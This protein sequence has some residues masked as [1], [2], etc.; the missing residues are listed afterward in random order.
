MTVAHFFIAASLV[1]D[2]AYGILVY[3]TNPK[4]G[5][6]RCFLLLTMILAIWMACVWNVLNATVVASAAAWLRG[7]FTA[8]QLIPTCFFLLRLAIKVPDEGWR[9]WIH[10]ARWFI[11]VNVAIAILCQTQAFMSGVTLP[12]L[13]HGGWEVAEPHYGPGFAI[14]NAYYLIAFGYVLIGYIQDIKVTRG[15]R[16]T[17]LQF[18]LLGC[19]ACILTG[20]SLAMIIPII[21]GSSRTAPMAP[22]CAIVLNAIIAYGIATK[23]IMGVALILRRIT[24][25]AL[26]T[27]LLSVVYLC[28]T[29]I[30]ASLLGLFVDEPGDWPQFIAA[31]TTAF[32]L[33]PVHGRLQRL[34]ARFFPHVRTVDV[35][36]LIRRAGR[37]LQ[38]ITTTDDLL[39]GFSEIIVSTFGIDRLVILLADDHDFREVYSNAADARPLHL[40]S[41]SPLVRAMRLNMAPLQADSLRR[42]R[43]SPLLDKAVSV[44]DK[45]TVA[46]T[47]GI[48]SKGRL[49]GMMLLGPRIS[50]RVFTAHEEDGL[51]ILANELAVALENSKLFTETRNSR[52]YND[53]LLDNLGS[54]VV[55]ANSQQIVTV[56]NRDAQRILHVTASDVIG[57]SIN[58]LPK[59]ICQ[60]LKETLATGLH[61]RNVDTQVTIPAGD[62]VYLRL[63]GSPFHGHTGENLGALVVFHDVTNLKTLQSQIRRSDRLAS[64]G[65]LSAGMAH[66]IKNPLVTIKTFTQLLP[67]RFDD[68]D[69][70]EN[71]V[72]LV[73]EEVKRIDSVVNQLLTFSRPARP[74]LHPIQMHTVIDN[75]LRLVQ[76]QLERHQIMVAK[77][78]RC[79]DDTVLGDANLLSQAF[80]NFFLNAQEAMQA[81]GI[82]K[83]GTSIVQNSQASRNRPEKRSP[84]SKTI[85]VRIE[86]SGVGIK[87][88]ELLRVFDPFFTTKSYGTGLGLAVAHGI[89][90]EQGGFIDVQSTEGKGTVFLIDFPFANSGDGS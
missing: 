48:H 82:L 55:A 10:K 75:S 39:A 40:D 7:A 79:T 1:I 72:S 78:Y 13:S 8:S 85:L 71:F 83:I 16:Q 45:L 35:P 24:A 34:V 50:G 68:V 33:A 32:A 4:R 3:A 47:V 62:R 80:V 19:G 90:D 67:E 44:M 17:E 25:T 60:T 63:G 15:L 14:F 31:L 22:A 42:R 84:G 37:T 51:R 36:T 49:T 12:D 52:I 77:D 56:F 73:S 53:I 27:V 69:F 64:M 18:V 23:R 26:L 20:I 29:L 89:I 21:T 2:V 43:L 54:G 59:P 61:R 76:Q 41:T 66:E 11:L 65:T 6:N 58:S 88:D 57:Q 46:C 5:A 86:D 74:T 30:S 87:E 28:V 81:G 38:T 9:E 70:R